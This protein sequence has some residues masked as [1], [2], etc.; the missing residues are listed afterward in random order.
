M[1]TQTILISALL[2][3]HNFLTYLFTPLNT[4]ISPAT[5]Q[6]LILLS[7][8]STAFIL[9]YIINCAVNAL[10]ALLLHIA[11]AF[12]VLLDRAFH[13]IA[14][15]LEIPNAQVEKMERRVTSIAL[16]FVEVVGVILDRVLDV[17]E[18]FSK[19]L[20]KQ[21]E[22]MGRKIVSVVMEFYF[23]LCGFYRR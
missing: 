4:H 8:A 15:F 18:G 11:E 7:A 6:L 3:I 16:E 17:I 1:N 13:V 10:G 2:A 9:F 23:V 19:N 20:D 5:R 14:A 22:K 21:I 12:G